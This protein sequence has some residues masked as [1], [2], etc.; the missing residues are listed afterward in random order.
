MLKASRLVPGGTS[1][2][3]N[4]GG[5]DEQRATPVHEKLSDIAIA[6]EHA[7]STAPIVVRTAVTAMTWRYALTETSYLHRY[8]P[9]RPPRL[10]RRPL[11]ES[12]AHGVSGELRASTITFLGGS[13]QAGQRINRTR[14]ELATHEH[15]RDHTAPSRRKGETTMVVDAALIL[16]DRD[17][18]Q[19]F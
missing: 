6:S 1:D 5:F 17:T 8:F 14:V 12:S 7:R 18:T 16:S 9:R 2:S 3:V 15:A 19:V 11:S 4:A 13:S 10:D